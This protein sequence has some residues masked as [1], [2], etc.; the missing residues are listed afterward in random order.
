MVVRPASTGPV[1]TFEERV[2][3]LLRLCPALRVGLEVFFHLLVDG[4]VHEHRQDDRCRAVDG[5]RHTGGRRAQVEARIQLLHVVQG[6][7]VDPGV[8][9]LAVDVRARRRV[10]AVQ[11]DRIERGGQACGRLADRQ[12]VEAAVGALGRALAGEHADRVLA[13]A[14]IGIDAAGIGIAARQVLLA[15][16]GEQL[17][18]GPVAGR[19]DLR[20]RLVAERL[21]VVLHPDRLAADLVLGD[22]V[23]DRLQ[24]HRPFAQQAQRLAGQRLQRIVVA[25]AQG[26]QRSVGLA[27]DQGVGGI[28]AQRF[29]QRRIGQLAQRLPVR[30]GTAGGR[31]LAVDAAVDRPALFGNLGQV[32][33][34]GAGDQ[35]RGARLL[36]RGVD[37]R[38]ETGAL[39]AQ[40]PA[41]VGEHPAD[42][43]IVEL[44]GNGRIDRYVLVLDVE[45]DPV[46]LPL[47]AHVAQRIL[48]AAAVVLVE[49]DQ[50]G[51][52]EHVDLLQLTGRAVVGGHHVHREIDQVHD[53]RV[54]LADA[55][56][57]HDHQVEVQRLQVADAILEHRIGGHV[58]AAGGHRSHVHA[59]A[60]QRVHADAVAQQ[61]T[62]A[63]APGRVHRDHGNTH[64]REA[65]QE[66]VEQ[67]VG[68][69]G[70]AG[71]AG[72][73]DAD[74][75]GA[76]TGQ[77]PLPAQPRQ[78]GFT[79]LPV[80]DRAE[81]PP[82][83][84]LKK[85][86]RGN[87][88]R[89]IAGTHRGASWKFPLA[90][91]LRRAGDHV[92]D[93]LHQAHL[94]AIVGVVD[95]FDAV[96]LQLADL[97]GGDGA[98]TAAEHA[99]M[100]RPALAQ[101]VHHVLEVLHVPALVAGQGDGVGILLQRRADH[102]L[103]AAVVA[104]VDDLGALGLDQPAH[105][106]D[107]R[108]VAV[109]QAGGSDEAQRGRIGAGRGDLAGERAHGDTG[110]E[111]MPRF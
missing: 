24:P 11:G 96:G 29:G 104:Q 22:L 84:D 49:H 7:H 109:E 8:A 1:A 95:A 48:G 61:R 9:D 15:Q 64:G 25:L 89:E 27:G 52:V 21:A 105:D 47:L 90:P 93:H 54:G 99:D 36:Q 38:L 14:A 107:R 67:L 44:A 66:T 103:H 56:G 20:H 45:R 92:A 2:D 110:I 74:H 87:F 28:E 111:V 32:A 85:G 10:F 59:V 86:A 51:V 63:A 33:H 53:L 77:L 30:L 82:D 16:E 97:L 76:A 78:L 57:L 72:A 81:H 100:R 5:H 94:H 68:D 23:G 46:A 37:L 50:L 60:A 43:R 101:H 70:L 98:A 79:V 91:F 73:G 65:G 88:P 4:G 19:G 83:P 39:P 18:P 31:R 35:H 69:R 75:R 3:L 108:V 41:Q 71:A 80:L 17:A 42:A 6:R 12:V 26:Q 13:T 62:P 55:G 106:V 40:Q 34:P 102:I 58:L